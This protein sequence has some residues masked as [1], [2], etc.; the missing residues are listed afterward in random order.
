[1]KKIEA[2]RTVD[3]ALEEL[4]KAILS[5]K[6]PAGSTLPPERK[7]AGRTVDEYRRHWGL[8]VSFQV[9]RHNLIEDPL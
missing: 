2:K 9:L 6:F 7:L 5:G 4:R 3:L 8:L 1:M